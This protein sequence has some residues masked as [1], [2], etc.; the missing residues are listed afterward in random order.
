MSKGSNRRPGKGFEDN[1]DAIF[2]KK[3]IERGRF[4]QDP[5]TGKLVP[6]NEYVRPASECN[7]AIHGDIESFVSPVDGS[8]IDDRKKLREHN[9][10]HGVVHTHEYGEG[11]FER[12]RKERESIINGSHPSCKAERIEKIKEAIHHHEHKR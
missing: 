12:H 1:F 11:Y 2:N 10:R 9:I 4:I 7:A 6:A 5:E 3:T 8:V